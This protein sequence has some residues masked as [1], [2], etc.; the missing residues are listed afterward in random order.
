MASDQP[1]SVPRPKKQ[2]FNTKIDDFKIKWCEALS[3]TFPTAA[4]S[5][6]FDV[7]ALD[8]GFDPLAPYFS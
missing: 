8:R 6:D 3:F 7:P 5:A 4:P 2:Y 1:E